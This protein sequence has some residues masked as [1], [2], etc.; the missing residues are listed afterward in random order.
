MFLYNI[1]SKIDVLVAADWLFWMQT[2]HVPDVM[3]TKA[4][5]RFQLV[6]LVD[7]NEEDGVT[8]AVQYFAKT[9]ADYEQYIAEHAP[10]L[11]DLAI[12]K[13]G[14]KV[15]SFRSLMEVVE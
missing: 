4:F 10:I 7:I 9:R 5:T 12:K 6:K 11:R 8:Y 13:W 1:T 15:I 3:A 2:A 14:D